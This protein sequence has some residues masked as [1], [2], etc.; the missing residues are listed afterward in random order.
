MQTFNY[1]LIATAFLL[2]AYGSLLDE[3]PVG[4]IGVA[5]LGAWIAW[6]F[7]RLDLRTQQLVKAGE[8]ALAVAQK[9]LAEQSGVDG[10]RL[11]E[12]VERP[13][14]KAATYGVVINLI[15]MT[16]LVAFVAAA[17]FALI[18]IWV[19]PPSD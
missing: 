10:I 9:H 1:F 7:H 11:I 16:I 13:T 14:P 19:S 6:W 17:V 5:G 4:A 12:T 15:Q 2:A 18:T 3:H 8:A